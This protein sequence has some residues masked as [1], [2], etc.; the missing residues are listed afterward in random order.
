M[1]VP[2]SRPDP[3]A[4]GRPVRW[5]ED[6]LAA[7]SAIAPRDIDAASALWD[8]LCPPWARELLDAELQE[9]TADG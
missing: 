3:R 2:P 4:L 9:P 8:R 7:L 1:S 6:D 5:S